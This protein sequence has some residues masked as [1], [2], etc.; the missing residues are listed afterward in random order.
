MKMV[1]LTAGQGSSF[2]PQVLCNIYDVCGN[3]IDAVQP[4]HSINP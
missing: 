3:E 4:G 1:I 2:F